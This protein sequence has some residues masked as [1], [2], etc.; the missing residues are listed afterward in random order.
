M[1]AAVLVP[2]A[3]LGVRLGGG[4]PKAL[5]ELGDVPMLVHAL[6]SVLAA[7]SVAAAVV[8]APADGVDA[9]RELLARELGPRAPVTV[10]PGGSTRQESVRRALDALDASCAVVLVHDAARPFVPVDVVESVV[11]AVEAGADAVVPALPVVDTV[12]EV[13]ADDA[14]AGAKERVVRT[15]DRATLRAVQTP[16][17]FRREVLAAAHDAS[18][19]GDTTDDAG[20]VERMGVP[21]AVVPG[22][23]DAFKVTRPFDLLLAEALLNRRRAEVDSGGVPSN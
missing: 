9:V 1:K 21:V 20:M 18:P 5:R 11:A 17:G 15:V 4:L 22:S 6:R 12:K 8:A 3:G 13:T 19:E 10:V 23:E 16:Q 2:A 14:P 7:P